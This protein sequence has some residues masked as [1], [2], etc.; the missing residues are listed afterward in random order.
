MIM[1][2]MG[3]ENFNILFYFLIILI[4]LGILPII[5]YKIFKK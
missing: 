4:L 1:E 3:K 5:L 2:I